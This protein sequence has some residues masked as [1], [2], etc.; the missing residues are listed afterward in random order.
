MKSDKPNAKELTADLVKLQEQVT[1]LTDK[2]TSSGEVSD[3][4]GQASTHLSS[5][6]KVM[7]LLDRMRPKKPGVNETRTQFNTPVAGELSRPEDSVPP[8]DI[9]LSIGRFEIKSLLGKGG[10]SLV[11]KALDPRLDRVVALKVPTLDSMLNPDSV[12]RFEKESRAVATL[13]HPNI[14]PVFEEGK[15]G[16]ISYIASAYIEG[17]NLS[18]WIDQH[19]P[20]SPRSAATIVAVIAE[21]IQHAHSRGIVHRDLKPANILVKHSQPVSSTDKLDADTIHVA[22]FGLAKMLT[23]DEHLTQTG[24]VLGTPA[25]ASPEQLSGNANSDETVHP[26]LADI[27]SMGA[28]LYFLL[29]GRPPHTAE[30]LLELIQQVKSSDPVSPAAILPILP[31]DLTAICLKAIEKSPAARYQSAYALGRDLQNFLDGKPVVAKPIGSIGKAIRLCQRNPIVSCLSIVALVSILAGAAASAWSARN[32]TLAAKQTRQQYRE[33][34]RVIDEYYVQVSQDPLFLS[35]SFRQQKTKLLAAAKQHYNEFLKTNAHDE[36]LVVDLLQ[37]EAYLAMAELE[38]DHLDLARQQ[39]DKCLDG[40][41]PQLSVA[42]DSMRLNVL[43]AKCLRGLG[44]IDLK[45]GK[46]NEAQKKLEESA[47]LLE[48]V[49]VNRGDDQ[50]LAFELIRTYQA[51]GNLHR[52]NNQLDQFYAY[53]KAQQDLLETV[54]LETTLNSTLTNHLAI[55]LGD[56]SLYFRDQGQPEKSLQCLNRSIEISE[57]LINTEPNPVW[58]A[59][60]GVG[61]LYRRGVFFA[62]SGKM[63]LAL[64]DARRCSSLVDGLSIHNRTAEF[65]GLSIEIRNLL[66]VCYRQTGDSERAFRLF[67]QNVERASDLADDHPDQPQFKISLATKILQL[68]TGLTNAWK[69][70][71]ALKLSLELEKQMPA[72]KALKSQSPMVNRLAIANLLEQGRIQFRLQAFKESIDKYDEAEAS[73]QSNGQTSSSAPAE[74]EMLAAVYDNRAWSHLQAGN[75]TLAL[76]DRRRSRSLDQLAPY[77][78][79]LSLIE[80]LARGGQVDEALAALNDIDFEAAKRDFSASGLAVN[81]AFIHGAIA[82]NLSQRSLAQTEEEE[83]ELQR[84]EQ[85]ELAEKQFLRAVDLGYFTGKPENYFGILL[86]PHLQELF[87]RPALKPILDRQKTIWES[88]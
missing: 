6:K 83:S 32:A 60:T 36:S 3:L 66:A 76:S 82:A 44:S 31:A 70:D 62:R 55:A 58:F 59:E 52:E 39:F 56:Q 85:L 2:A 16:P 80:T 73:L 4:S 78:Q 5:A 50:L 77:Y 13:S 75:L 17:T 25:F 86:R 29:T 42:S 87:A 84:K 72:L 10:F 88:R 71:E 14:V 67:Q 68:Q 12:A 21:A 7:Q 22:D 49:L 51:L 1:G 46:P 30:N 9:P 19:G 35:P 18:D 79:A 61:S 47:N 65:I 81:R 33:S 40:I 11:F 57:Q 15:D 38:A 54:A 48:S 63:E 41:G 8:P 24:N 23:S 53:S 20:I 34:K 26:E 27:Y 69:L 28:I 45:T 37:T 74:R 64:K 43:K